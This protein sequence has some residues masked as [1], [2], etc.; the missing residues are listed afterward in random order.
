MHVEAITTGLLAGGPIRWTYLNAPWEIHYL[1]MPDLTL[2]GLSCPALPTNGLQDLVARG[3]RLAVA[4][5]LTLR[6]FQYQRRDP[7]LY[8]PT[9]GEQP[10][11][12]R[13][14]PWCHGLPW[15]LTKYNPIPSG[16]EDSTCGDQCQFRWPS[17]GGFLSEGTGWGGWVVRN[18][19]GALRHWN[20]KT[21]A[22]P[23]I[24]W[25]SGPL[26]DKLDNII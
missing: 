3:S 24:W 18:C 26:W 9:L 13:E 15:R 20:P 17:L 21:T 11:V 2:E 19:S 1:Q 16:R 5:S 22:D 8:L 25:P 14:T 12:T 7:L 4:W 10:S 23:H 6:S